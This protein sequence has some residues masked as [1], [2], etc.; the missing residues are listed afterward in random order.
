MLALPDE[1]QL[2]THLDDLY[3]NYTADD[4]DADADESGHRSDDDAHSFEAWFRHHQLNAA[5]DII[6]EN[7]EDEEPCFICLEPASAL[8]VKTRVCG[9][10]F[11]NPCIRA[12]LENHM[13]CPVCRGAVLR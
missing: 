7:L 2:R 13:S 6:D 3:N 5:L 8:W 4:A 12:W 1:S 11:H 9:H 10:A